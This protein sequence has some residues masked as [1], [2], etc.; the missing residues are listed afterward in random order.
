MTTII[1]NIVLLITGFISFIPVFN[2]VKSKEDK[3][4][5]CLRYLILITFTWTIIVF[6]ERILV[7]LN[8][9]YTIHMFT[10]PLKFLLSASM[11]CTIFNYI[12]K[13]V[14]KW[15]IV[16][17]I[18]FVGL[19]LFVAYTNTSTQ[20]LLTVTLD[21]ITAFEDLYEG[22]RGSLFIVHL[23]VTYITL[24]LALFYMF[25]FLSKNQEKHHYKEITNTMIY[26]SIT[27]LVFNIL[28]LTVLKTSVDLTYVSL[29]IV[30]YLL[31]TVIY[32]K[33]MLFNLKT[34]GRGEILGN[35]REMY[36][37]T[38]SVKNI[39]DISPIFCSKYSINNDQYVGVNL[40]ELLNELKNK[41][42]FYTEINVDKDEDSTKDH[43]HVREKKFTLQGMN[44][45]G[46]M[47]LLYDETQVY[48]LLRELNKLSNFDQMTGLNN[49]NHIERKLE[50]YDNQANIGVISLDLNGLKA[51][52]DY[53]GHERG[54]YLLKELAIKMKEATKN[55]DQKELA[56]IGGDEF[57]IIISNTNIDKL[58]QIK[59]EL[60]QMCSNKNLIDEISVSIGIACSTDEKT[61]VYELIRN[62]DKDMYTMKQNTS[63]EYSARI[64]EYAEK[65]DKFIR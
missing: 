24:V 16:F 15:V 48:L 53:L 33:D 65:R 55:I 8:V 62:A 54:D 7:N 59:K 6:L 30:V 36:I 40:D 29:V 1:L 20:Y 26:S 38:D 13:K 3:R 41:I 63:K 60:L 23:L 51:N 18:I 32:R 12:G 34:S 14:P 11:L 2:V 43:L 50:Q 22:S 17:T 9:I 31:Y 37:L 27:V 46:Y 39:V 47:I 49:R 5:N 4:Y 25:L 10:Y 56:R 61:S 42:I 45:F 21:N 52:N 28:Q 57:I 44:E 35:M 19:E 64:V 58:K